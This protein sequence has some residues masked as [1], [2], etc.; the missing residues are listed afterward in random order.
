MAGSVTWGAAGHEFRGD[1]APGL[2]K[3]WDMVQLQELSALTIS[4]LVIVR[5]ENHSF[6]PGSR[7]TSTT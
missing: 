1:G 3:R 2:V 6:L 7:V 4:A 5:F